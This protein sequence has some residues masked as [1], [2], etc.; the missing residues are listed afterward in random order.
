MTIM[1]IEK[2]IKKILQVTF[3]KERS[4]CMDLD[5]YIC[6]QQDFIAKLKINYPT[7]E[8]IRDN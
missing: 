6:N 8:R 1:A 7:S 2:S 3:T 5:R 4:H